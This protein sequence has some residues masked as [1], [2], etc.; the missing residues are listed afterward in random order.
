MKHKLLTF[1]GA[2]A[3]L[4]VLGKFYAVPAIAQAVRAA[5]VKN[6]DEKGRIPWQASFICGNGGDCTYNF[7]AVPAHSRLVI[8]HVGLTGLVSAGTH[9]S[10]ALLQT[11][12][13]QFSVGLPVTLLAQRQFSD[14]YFVGGPTLIYFDAGVSLQFHAENLDGSISLIGLIS[15][16]LVDLSQ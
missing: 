2:L 13:G 1:A 8:E 5:V 14:Y 9:I 10:L 11:N 12:S 7:G 3:L 4:A 16:Y 15:G 6:I